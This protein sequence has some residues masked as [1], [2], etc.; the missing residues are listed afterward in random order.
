[1][2]NK[3]PEYWKSLRPHTVPATRY[4]VASR[5]HTAVSVA[6]WPNDMMACSLG[7]TMHRSWL[8]PQQGSSVLVH[9]SRHLQIEPCLTELLRSTLF[10][11]WLV[12]IVAANPECC[13]SCFFQ[14]APTEAFMPVLQGS[15]GPKQPREDLKLLTYI[16]PWKW[17]AGK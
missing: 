14:E 6:L 2:E 13:S 3:G 5:N 1:M 8:A 9:W 7:Q 15:H 17:R 10:W 12:G 11:A 4:D 16:R